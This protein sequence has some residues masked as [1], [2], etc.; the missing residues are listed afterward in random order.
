MV[1]DFRMIVSGCVNYGKECMEQQQMEVSSWQSSMRSVF[2]LLERM[3][4][5]GQV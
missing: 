1:V 2:A 5:Q 3:Y 4:G